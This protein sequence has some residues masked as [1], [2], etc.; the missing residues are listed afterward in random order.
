MSKVTTH[1]RS[2]PALPN[3]FLYNWWRYQANIDK[4]IY[5]LTPDV[6]DHTDTDKIETKCSRFFAKFQS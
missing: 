1:S 2:K 5:I 3:G 6:N 4:A